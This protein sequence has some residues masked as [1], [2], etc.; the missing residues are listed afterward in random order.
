MEGD[1]VEIELVPTEVEPARSSRPW[2]RAGD[3]HGRSGGEPSGSGRPDGADE[4]GVSG[5]GDS[6]SR[7]DGSHD[8]RRRL[9]VVGAVAV[10]LALL[11]GWVVG[12]AGS[13]SSTAEPSAS[14][15]ATTPGTRSTPS[16]TSPSVATVAVPPVDDDVAPTTVAEPVIVPTVRTDPFEVNAEITVGPAATDPRLAGLDGRVVGMASDGAVFDLD[17]ATGTLTRYDSGAISQGGAQ[18]VAGDDWVVISGF[19]GRS[20]VL[21]R[22]D[23]SVEPTEV[24]LEGLVLHT[25]GSDRFWRLP[26]NGFGPGPIELEEVTVE[27][28]ATGASFE[29]PSQAW[30]A[31]G[32]AL[33]GVAVNKGGRWFSVGPDRSS[34]LG[35]GELLALGP[36][37]AVA[38]DC[39]Q[40]DD[41]AVFRLD[42]A[43]GVSTRVALDRSIAGAQFIPSMWFSGDLESPL[44]PDGRRVVIVRENDV[45]IPQLVVIDLVDGTLVDLETDG[46]GPSRVEWLADGAHLVYLDMSGSPKVYDVETGESIPLFTEAPAPN[47]VA[48]TL[49]P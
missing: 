19:S 5:S 44:S 36:E 7:G 15:E 43:T 4:T 22:D 1:H 45:G 26:A 40:L 12:R 42:R 28:E 25:R 23:G 10:M 17:L 24:A 38:F 35:T 6:E 13:S 9:V 33:G 32:D 2:H 30:P 48:L 29:V 46:G 34:P 11:V 14:I 20:A 41:C 49:R 27:G 31:S 47:W 8:D 18:I 21:L 3:P 37:I 39:L 16:T